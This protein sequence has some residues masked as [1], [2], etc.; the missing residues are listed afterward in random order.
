MNDDE[1]I[2][3]VRES[4]TGVHSTTPVNQIVKRSRAVRTRR[5]FPGVA[6]ALVV[7]AG[8]AL[9]VSTLTPASHPPTPQLAAWTV[10]KQA[11]GTVSITVRE[12]RDPAGLQR[13]LRADGVPASVIFNPRLPRRAPF[14]DLFRVKNN[15]CQAYG[16][17]QG[18][19]LNVVGGG[20]P[21]Q[22]RERSTISIIH[23]SALP[24]GAGVQFIATPNTG[25]LQS[26]PDRYALGVLLV[27]ASQK[28]T[29]S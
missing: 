7:A 28:C 2:T 26:S 25:Y 3:T 23:P 12:F 18:Q 24:G 13:E 11:D 6:A 5:F 19:L 10:V 16:G 15:P 14:R 1:L 22:L 29:G 4:F 21:S 17:G 20:R 8:A 9:A 27:Q